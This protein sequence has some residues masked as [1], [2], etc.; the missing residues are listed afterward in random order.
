M[1]IIDVLRV[2]KAV[3]TSP[4][5]T[6][7][8]AEDAGICGTKIVTCLNVDRLLETIDVMIKSNKGE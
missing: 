7:Q 4:G 1:K 5:V 2:L 3:I 6:Y 8:V